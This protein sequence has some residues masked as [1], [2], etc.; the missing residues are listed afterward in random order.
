MEKLSKK[1]NKE[2][3]K[4]ENEI[5][6]ILVDHKIQDHDALDILATMHNELYSN[7]Y[8]KYNE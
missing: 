6:K 7:I 4:I 5:I 3:Q 1:K 2:Y 8:S